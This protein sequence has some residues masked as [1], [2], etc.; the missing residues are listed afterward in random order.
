MDDQLVDGELHLLRLCPLAWI[1]GKE[2]TVFEKMPTNYGPVDLRWRL[3]DGG[4]TLDV[5]MQGHWRNAPGKIVMHAPPVPG[6][7]QILVNGKAYPA[8]GE[9]L[10]PAD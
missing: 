8:V 1:S 7:Q 3:T 4:K 6:L 5:K 9:F 2:E 10:L